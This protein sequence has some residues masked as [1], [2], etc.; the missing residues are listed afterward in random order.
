MT[1]NGV[2]TFWGILIQ[3][4]EACNNVQNCEK[5]TKSC[6]LLS[7]NLILLSVYVIIDYGVRGVI[8]AAIYQRS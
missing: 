4:S 6:N 7:V 1:R 5:C 2:V 3:L 8:S